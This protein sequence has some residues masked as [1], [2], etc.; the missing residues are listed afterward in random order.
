MPTLKKRI[1]LELTENAIK[2]LNRRYLKKDE[3]GKP[4]EA[5][6]DMFERVALN[7]AEAEKIYDK[8]A[9]VHKA[10]EDFYN[11]MVMNYLLI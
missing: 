9:S 6:E 8:D 10:A 4:I 7:I 1:K 2:V 5:P 3:T 11:L